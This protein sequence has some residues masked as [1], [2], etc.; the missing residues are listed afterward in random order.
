MVSPDDTGPTEAG[1]L[2]GLDGL[3]EA[4]QF[5]LRLGNDSIPPHVRRLLNGAAREDRQGAASSFFR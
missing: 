1:A 3:E 4:T 5:S 2:Q